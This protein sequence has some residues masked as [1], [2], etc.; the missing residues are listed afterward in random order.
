[1]VVPQAVTILA[2]GVGSYTVVIHRR[3]SVWENV[4]VREIAASG[5]NGNVE[6]LTKITR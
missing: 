2:R 3:E 4:V 5:S 6:R 1:M